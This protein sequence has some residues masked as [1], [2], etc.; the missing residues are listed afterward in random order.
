MAA[1]SGEFSNFP[2]E[3]KKIK[4]LKKWLVSKPL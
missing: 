2:K 1:Y 3:K 4:F